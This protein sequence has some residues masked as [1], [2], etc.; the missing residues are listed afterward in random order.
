MIANVDT[1]NNPTGHH[2]HWVV[3]VDLELEGQDHCHG[4]IASVQV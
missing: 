3:A 2:S 4:R 1:T